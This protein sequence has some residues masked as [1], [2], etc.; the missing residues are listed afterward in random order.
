MKVIAAHE[1]AR[2]EKLAIESGESDCQ[3][4]EKAALGIFELLKSYLKSNQI[5]LSIT[6]IVG[7]GNNGGDA[8]LVACYLLDE[9]YDVKIYHVAK[10]DQCS[11]LCQ[12]HLSAFEKMGGKTF[13]LENV[14]E[15]DLSTKGIILD[16]L[17]GTGIS[18]ELDPYLT[19]LIKKIN[20]SRQTVFAVDIPSGLNGDD[21]TINPVAIKA[22]H[23][24][25]LG[26]AKTGFFYN[27]GWDHVGKLHY[28]DFGLEKKYIDLAQSELELLDANQ[29][30]NILPTIQ[31]S[32][33]KY[34]AGLVVGY[35]GSMGMMGASMLSGLSALRS[36]AG[37]VKLIHID[38]QHIMG[39]YPELIHLNFSI[40]EQDQ[41]LELINKAQAVYLGPGIGQKSNAKA[42]LKAVL[43]KVNKPLVIDADALNII[44]SEKYP[45]PENSI[46]TPH[47][48][49]M[50]KLLGKKIEGRELIVAAKDFA[51]KNKV[52]L[53]LKGG[54]TFIFHH[55]G[56][57]FVQYISDPGMA[58]AGSGDV[59]TGMITALLAQHTMDPLKAA[60]L[61]V[62][63][64]GYSGKEVAIDKTSYCIIASD[65]IEYLPKA[66][67]YLLKL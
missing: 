5:D 44:S 26:L 11:K 13:H 50:I 45:I 6:A 47:H 18:G 29:V 30:I 56:Q 3:F 59:L 34:Q 51:K 66:F 22:D 48:G 38:A 64:H 52:T 58:T 63:L 60:L 23:T 4:M 62:F 28:V 15:L 54:P 46:L 8:A 32:Q 53:V 12:K 16:G 2:V 24:I 7:K 27:Q 1:M 55:D 25:F 36:G 31:S 65:I 10:V 35:S 42:F 9:K 49:E 40:E 19:E 61:A 21:G 17:L 14:E 57:S 20:Q 41:A 39:F 67:Q 33:H 43:N 37:I